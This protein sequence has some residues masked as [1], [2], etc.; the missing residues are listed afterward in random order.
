M[1][2]LHDI[3][4]LDREQFAARLGFLFEG[5]PWIAAET[6]TARPFASPE[7]LHAALC[8]TV[9]A[10]PLES[11]IALIR[12]HPDLAGRAAVAREL[13]PESSREQASAGLDRLTPEE[14]ATFTRLNQAYRERFAFPFVI[15]VR[16]HDKAGILAQFAARLPNE[17]EAEVATAIG[18]IGKIAR[19]RLLDTVRGA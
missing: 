18:E 9:E 8:R 6:W 10:A 7:E 4:A 3:N 15:C 1:L 2:T 12:A 5:S 16:E 17:R 19:L 11:Q 13:T 14:F